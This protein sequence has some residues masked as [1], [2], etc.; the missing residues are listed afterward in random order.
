MVPD[1]YHNSCFKC[2]E[3]VNDRDHF[4]NCNSNR[5]SRDEANYLRL[6][7]EEKRAATQAR[8]QKSWRGKDTF[9]LPTMSN[10][11]STP[12]PDSSYERR[13]GQTITA[14]VNS[15]KVTE[16]DEE[17]ELDPRYTEVYSGSSDDDGPYPSSCST[18]VIVEANDA[19]INVFDN[20]AKRRRTEPEVEAVPVQDLVDDEMTTT[21]TRKRRNPAKKT[22]KK[23]T[24]KP[25]VGMLGQP[26]V[27]I[28]NLLMNTTITLPMLH[29]LQIA[30]KLR[31]ETR[32][33]MQMPRTSK[34]KNIEVIEV[35]VPMSSGPQ[36]RSSTQTVAKTGVKVDPINLAINHTL[37]QSPREP[38]QGILTNAKKEV[39]YTV[40]AVV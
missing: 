3:A 32:R 13:T 18:N 40:E 12:G 7:Y 37:L 14:N 5:L 33:L 24:L 34:K 36:T 27:D 39:A 25:I 16:D 8:N 31:E 11:N 2:G 35:E 21:T 10:S 22:G 30:P 1:L 28:Q 17:Y 4:M 9:A 29:A 38:I 23:R 20:K 15:V 19:E 26:D 6:Q